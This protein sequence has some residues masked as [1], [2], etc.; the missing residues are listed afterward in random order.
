M[1]V[2]SVIFYGLLL[3]VSTLTAGVFLCNLRDPKVV[4]AS[5][6]WLLLCVFLYWD[7][8]SMFNLPK[9]DAEPG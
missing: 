9:D 6:A 1:R 5:V 4:G 3:A 8:G 2:R 7:N